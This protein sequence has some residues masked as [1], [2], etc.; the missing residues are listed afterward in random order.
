M[1][2]GMNIMMVSCNNIVAFKTR[3]MGTVVVAAF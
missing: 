2:V 3:E 1:K